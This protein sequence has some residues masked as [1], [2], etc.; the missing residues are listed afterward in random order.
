MNPPLTGD[1]GARFLEPQVTCEV[2]GCK[3]DPDECKIVWEEDEPK[4][5][6]SS[7]KKHLLVDATPLLWGICR[8]C[9]G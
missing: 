1:L 3:V 5:D 4:L 7:Y 6:S 2:C 9:A 8:E